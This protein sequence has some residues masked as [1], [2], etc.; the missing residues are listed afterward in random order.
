M[1]EFSM[2]PTPIAYTYLN[3]LLLLEF[4]S[5][6]VPCELDNTPCLHVPLQK[7]RVSF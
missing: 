3:N 6:F 5:L 7:N 4:A 2:P 1:Y